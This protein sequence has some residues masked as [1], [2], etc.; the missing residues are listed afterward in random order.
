MAQR[1]GRRKGQ[2]GS[3]GLDRTT[4]RALVKDV[5]GEVVSGGMIGVVRRP[6]GDS[7]HYRV[8]DGDILVEVEMMPHGERVSARLGALVGGPTRGVWAIPDVETEV[9]VAFE[10]GEFERD[11][12][13]VAVLASGTAPSDLALGK[14]IV[15][16][17]EVLVHDGNGGAVSLA[18]KSELQAVVTELKKHFDTSVAG[19]KH[20][21]VTVGSGSTGPPTAGT[22]LGAG[23][24][25]VDPDGTSILKGK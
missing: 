12:Y 16:G 8:E 23:F 6:P 21:G 18:K 14:V 2:K 9:V 19:H 15:I 24:G 22:G 20:A 13:I 5:L 7:T 1:R 4:L 17:T 10:Q 3:A 11:P 25:F